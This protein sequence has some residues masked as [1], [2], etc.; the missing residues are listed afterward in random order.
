MCSESSVGKKINYLFIAPN[1]IKIEAVLIFVTKLDLK[2]SEVKIIKFNLNYQ[3]KY[4]L[5]IHFPSF[6]KIEKN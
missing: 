2:V 4:F 6:T 1:L 5:I 3:K